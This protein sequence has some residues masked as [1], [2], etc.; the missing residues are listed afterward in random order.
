LGT[1]IDLFS[2]WIMVLIAMGFAAFN[3]KKIK[4]GSAIG[5]VLSVWAV[6]EAVRVGIAFIF[7]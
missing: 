5:M 1:A 7:S 2:F 4:M 6:Y 3:P